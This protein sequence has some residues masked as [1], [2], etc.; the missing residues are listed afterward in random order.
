MAAVEAKEQKL[1][2]EE[3]ELKKEQQRL[4]ALVEEQKQREEEKHMRAI[5]EREKE[6][7]QQNALIQDAII[8]NRADEQTLIKQPSLWQ[9]QPSDLTN[10]ESR[11]SR[12]EHKSAQEAMEN[13][14]GMN[15]AELPEDS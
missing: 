4:N 10:Q 2:E 8:D 1:R 14:K 6:R 9:A 7:Q 3:E 5:E 12:G 15:E 11:A 13:L